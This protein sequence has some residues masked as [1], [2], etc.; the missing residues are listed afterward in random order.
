MVTKKYYHFTIHFGRDWLLILFQ[1]LLFKQLGNTMFTFI[2]DLIYIILLGFFLMEK[3]LLFYSKSIETNCSADE[4]GKCFDTRNQK[5]SARH[6]PSINYAQKA[7][8]PTNIF[9]IF[10]R[11]P[12]Q[13]IFSVTKRGQTISTNQVDRRLP[14]FIYSILH[15]N[16]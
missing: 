7:F 1:H 3:K 10:E 15:Y 13:S 11:F 12:F 9:A 5:L 14:W 4:R 16:S 8:K 2:S 6:I